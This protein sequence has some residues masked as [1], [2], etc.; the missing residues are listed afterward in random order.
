MLALP[1]LGSSGVVWSQLADC[2][3][4]LRI[5]SPDL[6]G[7]GLSS[8][9]GGPSGL[10]HHAQ[11]VAALLDELD[12]DDVVV[13][14]HSMGAYLAPVVAEQ[15]PTRVSR[16]VL[17]DGGV[18]ARLPFYMKAPVTRLVWKL[19]MRKAQRDW[20]DADSFAR[21]LFSKQIGSRTDLL[22][23]ITQWMEYELN[24][25]PGALRPRLATD[26]AVAD[27]VDVFH[28]SDARTALENL[29]VPAHLV[30]AAYRDGDGGKP[31]LDD[32]TLSTW[33]RRLPLL[34]TERVAGT[35]HVSVVFSDEVVRALLSSNA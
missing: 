10:H 21:T 9:V 6:R 11:D 24:G 34:T 4:S 29:R 20:P 33:E 15:A 30:A 3:P 14:G 18:P 5:L 31:F 35:N 32:V 26:H 19:A 12:V 8:S 25:P 13:L 28:G 17:V 22:P 23:I 27:A 7:R 16:L 2:I 1:G